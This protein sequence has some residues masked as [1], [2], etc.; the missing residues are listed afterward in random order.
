M[1]SMT[2]IY[3]ESVVLP[4]STSHRC[5]PETFC[6]ISAWLPIG[7]RYSRQVRFSFALNCHYHM[8]SPALSFSHVPPKC[9][10]CCKKM[11]IG[12]WTNAESEFRV[13][14]RFQWTPGLR[15]PMHYAIFIVWEWKL[16]LIIWAISYCLSK[17]TCTNIWYLPTTCQLI[18]F[19]QLIMC[20]VLLW[21]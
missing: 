3:R 15:N 19:A 2:A 21:A 7:Q 4:T 20:R 13:L 14:S 16:L 8:V 12:C 11:R 18:R 6:V 17:I 1:L 9:P 5:L 10:E